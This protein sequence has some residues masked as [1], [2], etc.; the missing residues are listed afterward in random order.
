M[1]W[2]FLTKFFTCVIEKSERYNER[3]VHPTMF[4]CRSTDSNLRV[5]DVNTGK[6]QRIMQG[7]ANERNFVGMATG[8]TDYVLC[9]MFLISVQVFMSEVCLFINSIIIYCIY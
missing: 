3:L 1:S 5:W 2:V 4:F 8:G 7:H 9:G 6:C